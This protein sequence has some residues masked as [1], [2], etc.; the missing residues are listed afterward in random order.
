LLAFVH[1]VTL[2]VLPYS[3]DSVSVVVKVLVLHY[4]LIFAE[5][6]A[7]GVGVAPEDQTFLPLL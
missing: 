5:I 1:N 6:E 2:F 7:F 4:F 3:L